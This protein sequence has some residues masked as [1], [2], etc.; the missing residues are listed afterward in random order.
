[1]VMAI[2]TKATRDNW[3]CRL[4]DGSGSGGDGPINAARNDDNGDA[5]CGINNNSEMG[6]R[7][8]V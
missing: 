4:A 8:S 7:Q 2:A 5:T 6:G 3:R 1:M